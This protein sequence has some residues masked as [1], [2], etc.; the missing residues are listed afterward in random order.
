MTSQPPILEKQGFSPI[1]RIVWR[2][3]TWTETDT[4]AGSGWEES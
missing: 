2:R 4:M 1:D 3:E